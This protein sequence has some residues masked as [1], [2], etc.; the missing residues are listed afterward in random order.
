[1]RNN[2]LA[3]VIAAIGSFFIILIGVLGAGQSP[4]PRWNLVETSNLVPGSLISPAEQPD[5]I[6]PPNPA[7]SCSYPPGWYTYIE[8]DAEYPE[9]VNTPKPH[10]SCDPPSIEENVHG[11]VV[12]KASTCF[13]SQ[14]PMP[15]GEPCK[16]H[17]LVI[18][19]SNEEAPMPA[20][21]AYCSDW[22]VEEW[23]LE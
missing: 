11:D 2:A 12:L 15:S 8:V 9:E 5:G 1:M 10:S 19:Q 7:R 18:T 6:C 3:I 4:P 14:P 23:R 22:T 16:N 17:G 21:Y 20:R 13:A